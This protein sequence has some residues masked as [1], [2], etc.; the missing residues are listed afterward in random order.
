MSPSTE[1]H[2]PPHNVRVLQKWISAYAKE[3]EEGLLERRY[4]RWRA[5]PRKPPN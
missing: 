4:Q 1:E 5:T 3:H 2:K